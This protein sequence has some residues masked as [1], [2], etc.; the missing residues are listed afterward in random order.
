VPEAVMLQ[1]V[2]AVIKEIQIQD[3][4]RRDPAVQKPLYDL[5]DVC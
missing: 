2:E 4:L 3:I 5:E 1:I